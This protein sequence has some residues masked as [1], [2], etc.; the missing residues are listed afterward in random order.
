MRK[1]II[2]AD[3]FGLCAPVNRAIVESFRAGNLTSTTMMVAM[4]GTEEGAQL[5]AENPGL[6]IGLHFCLTEGRPLTNA[7]SLVDA[8]G[9]FLERGALMKKLLLGRVKQAE[10][11]AEF[12]AQYNRLVALG[13]RP[14]H[15]DSHQHTHMN[16]VV[17][18]AM[19]PLLKREKLSVRLAIP[20]RPSLKLLFTRPPKFVKQGVLYNASQSFRRQVLTR[21]NDLLVSV[22]DLSTPPASYTA[23]ILRAL[24]H[25][26]PA[27]AEVIELMVHPYIVG[28]ELDELYPADLAQRQPFFEK[29]Y[30]EHRI[31]TGQPLFEADPTVTLTTYGKL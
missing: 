2:N 15:T 18:G 14:T 25:N 23:D 29:C 28:P 12:E 31:L 22:H 30:A 19:L 26:A 10:V 5:A 21:T 1:V 27:S 6:A 9:N 24:V 3:D 16:P 8:E 4:P 13:I 11:A 7:A 20:V 17:F